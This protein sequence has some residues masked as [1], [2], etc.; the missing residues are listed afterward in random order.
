MQQAGSYLGLNTLIKLVI[1]EAKR[2]L[3]PLRPGTSHVPFLGAHRGNHNPLAPVQGG[4]GEDE[5][6]RNCPTESTLLSLT[7]KELIRP[8]RPRPRQP[9]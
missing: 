8:F 6:A 2:I 7:R 3:V 1:S 4:R 5:D 9:T